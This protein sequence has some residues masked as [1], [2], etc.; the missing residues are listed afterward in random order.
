MVIIGLLNKLF[1]R[2]AVDMSL[3]VD[4]S[5]QRPDVCAAGRIYPPPL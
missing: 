4:T 5:Q 2:H 3:A 1:R